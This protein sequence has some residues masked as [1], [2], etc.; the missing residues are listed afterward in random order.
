MPKQRTENT[1]YNKKREGEGAIAKENADIG[2]NHCPFFFPLSSTALRFATS[3]ASF[4]WRAIAAS[5]PMPPKTSPTPRTCMRVRRWPKATTD[6]IMV[7][8][9]RV[10]V[11]V[12]RRTEEKVESV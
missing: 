11:T 12:T 10:T 7:N 9:L 5:T 8:I 6:R 4:S 1:E 2:T 3:L